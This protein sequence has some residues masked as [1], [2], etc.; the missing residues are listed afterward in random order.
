[1]IVPG[2]DVPAAAAIGERLRAAIEARA[3]EHRHAEP[4]QVTISVGVAASR[5]G[6]GTDPEALVNE[7]DGALYAAKH[8]GRNRVRLAT[9]EAYAAPPRHHAH[10]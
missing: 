10:A 8:A 4:G 6:A 2:A 9:V 1:V 7:A 3:F 5:A